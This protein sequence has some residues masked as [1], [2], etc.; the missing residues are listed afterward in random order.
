MN[1]LSKLMD[2]KTYKQLFKT[3]QILAFY[4]VVILITTTLGYAWKG[5]SGIES[6]I[7]VGLVI[8]TCMWF[9]YGKKMV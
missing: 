2:L 3:Y 7:V 1:M 5:K 6:G 8:S 9:Q 4:L